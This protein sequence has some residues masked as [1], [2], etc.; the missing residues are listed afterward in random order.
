MVDRLGNLALLEAPLNR[1]LGNTGWT[2][3]REALAKSAVESTSRTAE[4]AS[5][6]AETITHRQDGQAKRAVSIWRLDP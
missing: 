6:D 1:A 5:W 3:K 4:Q 2:T